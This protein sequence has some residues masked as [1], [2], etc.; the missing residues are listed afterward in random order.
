[1]KIL[2]TLLVILLIVLHTGLYAQNV[3]FKSKNFEDKAGFKNAV[4]NLKKGDGIYLQNKRWMLPKALEYYKIAHEYNPNNALLNYKMGN[5]LI[6]INDKSLALPYF[7]K[8]YE[9]D[10]NVMED[11]VFKLAMAYHYN[12][13]W[14]NAMQEYERYQYNVGELKRQEVAPI[15]EKRIM[16]CKS[17]IELLSYPTRFKLTNLGDSVNSE[18]NDYAPLINQ[19]SNML[20]FTS[21]RENVGKGKLDM[22][23]EEYFED[24]YVCKMNNEEWSSPSR[25][26]NILNS[27]SHDASVGLSHDGRVLYLYKGLTNGGDIYESYFEDGIWTIPRPLSTK[28]NSEYHETSAC[29]SPDGKTLYFASD[30]ADLS[31]GQRDIFVS[32][33]ENGTWSEAVNIG[34]VI[35]TK[36]D[37]EG[38]YMHPD[39]KTLF[40]SSKGHNTMGGYDIFKSVMDENGIWSEPENLGYPINSPDDEMYFYALGVDDDFVGYYATIRSDGFGGRDIYKVEVVPEKNDV[41]TNNSEDLLSYNNGSGNDTIV[42]PGD[43]TRLFVDLDE[44]ENGNNQGKNGN[45]NNLGN[46]NG[47]TGNSGNSNGNNGNNQSDVNN[48]GNSN[49]NQSGNNGNNSGDL[50]NN[51]NGNQNSTNN[52]QNDISTFGVVF[53]VQVGASRKPMPY[54]ELKA[55]YPGNMKV[56]EIQHE[57]WYKYIIGTYNTYSEATE[58]KNSCGTPD[59]WVIVEKSGVRVHIREVLDMLSHYSYYIQSFLAYNEKAIIEYY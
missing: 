2:N 9:L 7:Q 40:F 30:R 45:N 20:I 14:N 24:I 51:T 32:K 10:N 4:A 13:E 54:N 11:I 28:I 16:E 34:S 57:G 12:M 1:M 48:N 3:E 33:F 47:N 52:G 6:N 23:M 46:N 38:V 53:K 35:N 25:L 29:L 17:G 5:C 50:A 44:N 55:R 39:G 43:D 31:V 26:G 42:I 56:T 27:S 59:A 37:E 36:Y 58:V 21:R 19:N 49:D 18:Y 22:D 15:I 41:L 8:A